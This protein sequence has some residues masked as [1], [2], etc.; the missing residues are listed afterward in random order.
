MTGTVDQFLAGLEQDTTSAT[1]DRTAPA[2]VDLSDELRSQQA[3]ALSSSSGGIGGTAFSTEAP[4]APQALDE[5]DREADAALAPEDSTGPEQDTHGGP[6]PY[7]PSSWHRR[8]QA[9]AAQRSPAEP[10]LRRVDSLTPAVVWP[11]EK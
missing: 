2:T 4:L 1:K 6:A 11:V 10:V 7:R 8:A 9:L 5:D 3:Q